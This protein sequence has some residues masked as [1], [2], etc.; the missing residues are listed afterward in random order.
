MSGSTSLGVNP[1]QVLSWPKP[2]AVPDG[3]WFNIVGACTA[4]PVWGDVRTHCKSDSYM[5]PREVTASFPS[6][7]G[8]HVSKSS[9]TDRRLLESGKRLGGQRGLTFSVARV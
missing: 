4:L 7:Q 1:V 8:G 2:R 3:D 9:R 5:G 6:L